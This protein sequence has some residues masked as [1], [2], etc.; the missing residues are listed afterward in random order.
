MLVECGLRSKLR[1]RW[2][3]LI[4]VE[5]SKEMTFSCLLKYYQNLL[6]IDERIILVNY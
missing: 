4:K 2:Q 6:S 5:M 1:E 3:L